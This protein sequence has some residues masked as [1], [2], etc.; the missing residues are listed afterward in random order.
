MARTIIKKT[1]KLSPKKTVQ[2]I[3][4]KANKRRSNKWIYLLLIALIIQVSG[5]ILGY[6]VRDNYSEILSAQ[7]SSN[8]IAATPLPAPTAVPIPSHIYNTFMYSDSMAKIKQLQETNFWSHSNED[9]KTFDERA[10]GQPAAWYGENLY[11]GPCDIRNAMALF[12][13][14]PTHKANLDHKYDYASIVISPKTN[15]EPEDKGENCYMV[16]QFMESKK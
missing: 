13:K 6:F 1:V 5:F 14:S 7:T 4:K 2:K 15:P 12:E 9:G 11:K 3:A 16:F 10:E 8:Q